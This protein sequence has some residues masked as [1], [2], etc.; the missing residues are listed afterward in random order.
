MEREV[1]MKIVL[2][3]MLFD[4]T[5]RWRIGEKKGENKYPPWIL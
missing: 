5:L 4:D 3:S 1:G 2:P